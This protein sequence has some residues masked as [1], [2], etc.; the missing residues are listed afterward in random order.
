M[1]AFKGNIGATLIELSA[2]S[3]TRFE[4]GVFQQMLEKMTAAGGL[5][6]GYYVDI[7]DSTFNHD[8]DLLVEFI[9]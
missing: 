8:F 3:F 9:I 7:E 5:A 4:S 6:A 1:C 2:N